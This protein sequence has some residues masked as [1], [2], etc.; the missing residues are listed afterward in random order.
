M[1]ET[2]DA[3]F[4]LL[5]ASTLN[6]TAEEQLAV[7]E[8]LIDTDEVEEIEDPP[9]PYGRSLAFDHEARK[10]P[11]IGGQPNWTEGIETLI[12][13]IKNMMWTSRMAHTIFSD[14]FGM[15]DPWALVGAPAQAAL[16]QAYK[17]DLNDALLVHDRIAEV[18]SIQM[19]VDPEEPDLVIV[20]IEITTDEAEEITIEG[21]PVTS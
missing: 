10:F 15:D 5:P 7:S 19:D 2:F 8:A 13:W 12:Q 9:E 11:L 21:F 14:D 16:W 20:T 17:T 4:E 18:N 3:D 6:V 1:A